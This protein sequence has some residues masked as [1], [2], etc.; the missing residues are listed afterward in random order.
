MKRRY[1]ASRFVTSHE[2]HSG[3]LQSV[4]TY[5]TKSTRNLERTASLSKDR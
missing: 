1:V 4:Y 5:N 3:T 2:R